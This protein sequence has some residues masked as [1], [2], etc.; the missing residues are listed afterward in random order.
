MHKRQGIFYVKEHDSRSPFANERNTSLKSACF[1]SEFCAS[2]C[3]DIQH[4]VGETGT[5]ANKSTRNSATELLKSPWN[6][7]W[8]ILLHTNVKKMLFFLGCC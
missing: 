1:Q 7:G 4:I 6:V 3:R 8:Q 5:S 2:S